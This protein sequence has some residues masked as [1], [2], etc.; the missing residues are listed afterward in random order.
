[1]ATMVNMHEAKT[2]LSRLAKRAASGE[3]IVIASHGKPVAMLTKLPA[4][5]KKIPWNMY[6]GQIDIADDFDALLPEFQE[7]T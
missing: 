5:S 7:Y 3:E 6:K 1:M 4:Q 2:N